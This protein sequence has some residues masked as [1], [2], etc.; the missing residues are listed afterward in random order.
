MK[1]DELTNNTNMKNEQVEIKNAIIDTAIISNDDQGFLDCWLMLDYGD[2][3]QGF[4]GWVLYVPKSFTHHDVKSFAVH[5]IHRCM[6]VAGVGK[7]HELKGKTI[8][9]K[10]VDGS[11]EAIGHIVKEDWYSPKTDFATT[12]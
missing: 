8:R 3:C 6:E 9:A 7:F 12:R 1:K 5:H 2:S 11:I 10:V 4:G